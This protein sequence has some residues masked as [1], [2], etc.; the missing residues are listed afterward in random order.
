MFDMR[1][2]VGVTLATQDAD[3]GKMRLGTFLLQH[4]M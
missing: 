1:S 3:A 2:H 4:D